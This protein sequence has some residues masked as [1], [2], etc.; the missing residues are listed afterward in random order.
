M[1]TWCD[2]RASV[3]KCDMSVS[4]G[5]IAQLTSSFLQVQTGPDQVRTSGPDD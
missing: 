3:A 4:Q 5:K 1:A 2:A